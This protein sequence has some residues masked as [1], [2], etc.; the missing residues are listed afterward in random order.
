MTIFYLMYVCKLLYV[1]ATINI[2][3][4]VSQKKAAICAWNIALL[5]KREIIEIESGG[6]GLLLV[7]P[8]YL[9]PITKPQPKAKEEPKIPP[10]EPGKKEYIRNMEENMRLLFKVKYNTEKGLEAIVSKFP[11]NKRISPCKDE[12]TVTVNLPQECETPST[13]DKDKDCDYVPGF[14]LGI[15]P[16]KD[17][18]PETTTHTN[19][20]ETSR[21][22]D[23]GKKVLDTTSDEINIVG[24]KV[25][26]EKGMDPM[27][28]RRNKN[29][30]DHLRSPF[31]I[32]CVNLQINVEDKRV[33][34]WA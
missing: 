11:N 28:Q 24:M 31:V 1:E 34:E 17:A 27:A 3:V 29:L 10:R 19:E 33:N 5:R 12:H 7:R 4:E 18:A 6:F 21:V 8:E 23:K 15:S 25:D 22:K 16:L 9:I 30:S 20:D 26:E 13:K 32:R 2:K 14:D